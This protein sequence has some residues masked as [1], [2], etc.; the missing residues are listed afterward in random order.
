[1]AL[2]SARNLILPD[3]QYVISLMDDGGVSNLNAVNS[4]TFALKFKKMITKE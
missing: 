1:V 3:F 4:V 2:R